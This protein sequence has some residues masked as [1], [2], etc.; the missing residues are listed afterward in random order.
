MCACVWC[1]RVWGDGVGWLVACVCLC[2]CARTCVLD[3]GVGLVKSRT[4]PH[5]DRI[6]CGGDSVC[7]RVWGGWLVAYVCVCVCVR[8]R[9][10]VLDRGV[11]LVK[12]RTQPHEDRI[13]CV[14]DACVCVC[15]GVGVNI[16]LNSR[17]E[18]NSGGSKSG[19]RDVCLP[20]GPNSF[21]FMQF[22]AKK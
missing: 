15:I 1:V 17:F 3:R 19:T 20:M 16:F 10:G 13:V 6:V 4:Q 14:G 9:T 11:G 22:S 18:M 7:V 21:I 12:S 8:A 5:E 2:V